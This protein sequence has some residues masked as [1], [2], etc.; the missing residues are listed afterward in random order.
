MYAD[1]MLFGQLRIVWTFSSAT[2]FAIFV[3][4]LGKVCR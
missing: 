4:S 2:H 3:V 1:Y